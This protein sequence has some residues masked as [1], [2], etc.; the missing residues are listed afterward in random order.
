MDRISQNEP[1]PP[2]PSV[3]NCAQSMSALSLTDSRASSETR[4]FEADSIADASNPEQSQKR[5]PRKLT[6]SRVNSD[7]NL[8]TRAFS[9][10]S[11]DKGQDKEKKPDDRSEERPKGVLTKKSLQRQSWKLEGN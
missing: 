11:N 2:I 4:S 5:Q 7:T 6:K 8:A 3:G 9:S 1:S 10:S